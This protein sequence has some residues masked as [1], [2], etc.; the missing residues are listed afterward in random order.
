VF[1]WFTENARA[2]ITASGA[3]AVLL[4]Q[5]SAHRL[6]PGWPWVPLVD[7]GI[8]LPTWLARQP[9][10]RAVVAQVA[11]AFATAQKPVFTDSAER[12]SSS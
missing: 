11:D 7:P 12:S 8:S 9:Q 3:V 6:L 2:C 4:T 10:V 1:A 5:P